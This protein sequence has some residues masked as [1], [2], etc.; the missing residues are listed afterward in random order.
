MIFDPF[1]GRIAN[2]SLLHFTHC[3]LFQH[4]YE[5]FNTCYLTCFFKKMLRVNKNIFYVI[6]N[7]FFNN[8]KLKIFQKFIRPGI[9]CRMSEE[10][11][12]RKWS[13]VIKQSVCNK[14]ISY[15]PE[16][17]RTTKEQSFDHIITNATTSKVSISR[18]FRYFFFHYFTMKVVFLI[19]ANVRIG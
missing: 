1:E 3:Q 10:R 5:I 17:K 15:Q 19:D 9:H 7:V 14:L 13:Q 2:C 4:M 18:I 6:L 16:E 12:R 8:K 11:H